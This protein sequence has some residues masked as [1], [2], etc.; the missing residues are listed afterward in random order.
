MMAS[1]DRNTIRQNRPQARLELRAPYDAIITERFADEGQIVGG[2]TPVFTIQETAAYEARIGINA[3]FIANLTPGET[4]SLEVNKQTVQATIKAIIPS[5]NAIT[6]T[7]DVIF[8]LQPGTYLA[9]EIAEIKMTQRIE[10]SGFWV[11]LRALTEGRRGIWNTYVIVPVNDAQQRYRV[12]AQPVEIIYQRDQQ[13]LI[14]G[15]VTE[16]SRYIVS[17][18]HRVVPG[19]IVKADW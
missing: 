8:S 4:H 16:G 17:G 2:G 18:L 13:V 19:Q 7:V 11:P 14:R 15:A 1:P 6:R 10:E 5:R 9:G 3:S 12:E